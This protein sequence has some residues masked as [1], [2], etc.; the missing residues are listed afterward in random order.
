[1][2]A[3][4]ALSD[5]SKW[6]N[7][8]VQFKSDLGMSEW[9]PE[10]LE[11]YLA[12][13]D[14]LKGPESAKRR[15][16]GI[17]TNP[18]KAWPGVSPALRSVIHDSHEL[19]KAALKEI[20][21]QRDEILKKEKERARA[22][23]SFVFVNWPLY[24]KGRAGQFHREKDKISL[25]WGR[26][27]AEL[28]EG[29]GT[30]EG[31]EILRMVARENLIRHLVYQGLDGNR[32]TG[33]DV[34]LET[35][36]LIAERPLLAPLMPLLEV[37]S[38]EPD[39]A[40]VYGLGSHAEFGSDYHPLDLITE[41]WPVKYGKH[42]AFFVTLEPGAHALE[43]INVGVF[44]IDFSIDDDVQTRQAEMEKEIL[45]RLNSLAEEFRTV[46]KIE[47]PFSISGEWNDRGFAIHVSGLSR[48]N[49]FL[50]FYYVGEALKP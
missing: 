36:L 28:T 11:D 34:G 5:S 17:S 25:A 47:K 44:N 31:Y 21:S 42:A 10:E 16:L 12:M 15:V 37:Y 2:A 19:W 45:G 46:L 18:E 6:V 41:S 50:F 38:P 14:S 30:A 27:D 20:H 39:F 48:M 32:H 49:Q 35:R 24:V 29:L 9:T 8:K 43:S 1:M 23:G 7:G 4:E 40:Y 22:E 13:A 33:M 26:G 3:M